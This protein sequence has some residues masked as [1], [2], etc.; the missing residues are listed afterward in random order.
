MHRTLSSLFALLIALTTAAACSKPAGSSTP[1]NTGGAEAPASPSPADGTEAPPEG[2]T[3]SC[4]LSCSGT[5]TRAYGATEEEAHANA[6]QLVD[7]KCRP[8]DGQHFIFCDP[9][10]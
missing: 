1:S 3:Y 7:D 9:V 4:V 2:S 6:R 10:E 5:E 8:E